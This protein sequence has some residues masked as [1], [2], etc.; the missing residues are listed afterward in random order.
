MNYAKNELMHG[1][2]LARAASRYGIPEK[3]LI[4]FSASI[5]PLGPASGVF[6]AIKD[7]LWRICHYPDPDC[8]DLPLLLAEHLGVGKKNIVLGNGGAEII[9][10]L[11]RALG[12]KRALIIEPTFG[13]YARAVEEAG[14]EVRRVTRGAFF[15]NARRHLEGCDAIFL[16]NPNNPTGEVLDREL[17]MRVV[18]EVAERRALFVVDEAFMDFVACREKISVMK[19]ACRNPGI[20]VLYSMTKFF[21][22]PGLRLGAAVAAEGVAEKIRKAKDPWSVNALAVVAGEAAL[23]D[24][25]HMENTLRVVREEREFVFNAI[26]S[27]PGLRPLPSE[28]N[29]IM[30]DI[31]GTG[32]NSS[33]LVEKLGE[34]GIMVRDCSNFHGLYMP[35]IRVAIRKREDN[36]VLVKALERVLL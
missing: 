26:S 12:I 19:E 24:R 2:N 25:E 6:K 22:I 31:T 5:N 28:V 9:Y 16:C 29:F 34:M 13:E 23:K 11:P 33:E 15:E 14:G 17:L 36:E 27:I 18:G 32:M 3:E 1:G 30:V 35:C 7:E 4:D 20:V 8:G 10:I 21:G